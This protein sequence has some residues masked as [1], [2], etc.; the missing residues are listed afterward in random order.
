MSMK[1]RSPI[2][3]S[4]EYSFYNSF[5]GLPPSWAT[6][7]AQAGF[8]DDEIAEIHARRAAGRSQYLFNDRP[9]S[10]AYTA[11]E[12]P[13]YAHSYPSS[14]S[15]QTSDAS[16]VGPPET[17]QRSPQSLFPPRLDSIHSF[18]SPPQPMPPRKDSIDSQTSSHQNNLSISSRMRSGSVDT[19]MSNPKGTSTAPLATSPLSHSI[20][21]STPTRRTFHVT[22]DVTNSPP[23]SYTNDSTPNRKETAYPSEKKDASFSDPP[24]TH[25]ASNSVSSTSSF[26]VPDST[27][28]QTGPVRI[29]PA[30]TPSSYSSASGSTGSLVL[31]SRAE[32]PSKRLT[33]LP[34]RLSLHKSTDST[35]LSSW[36]ATLLSGITAGSGAT[37]VSSNLAPAQNAPLASVCAGSGQSS[38]TSLSVPNPGPPVAITAKSSSAAS[39]PPANGRAPPPSRPVP[40]PPLQD[41]GLQSAFYSDDDD[42]ETPSSAWAEPAS[43]ARYD[44]LLDNWD[45]AERPSPES[46]ETTS[47]T[48]HSLH[49]PTRVGRI[50]GE[51]SPAR[52]DKSR[53]PSQQESDDEDESDD[54]LLR[55]RR[56]MGA[57]GANRDSS[58]S[59]T[60]TVL[61]EP[62]AIVR[63]VSIARRVEAY[64]IDNSKV[65]GRRRTN[66]GGDETGSPQTSP[67]LG[68]SVVDRKQPPSPLSSNFGSEEGSASTSGSSST[69]SHGHQ[70]PGSEA[71]IASP[72]TYYLDSSP[73]PDPSKLTFPL[74]PHSQLKMSVIDTFGIVKEAIIVRPPEED[75]IVPSPPLKPTI[76]ITNLTSPGPP[77]SLTVTSGGTTPRTPFQRYPGWLSSVVEP[78]EQFIDE[79]VD[80][81]DYYLDLHEIAEGDSGSVFA[82]RLTKTNRHKLKLP[83]LIKARDADDL[84]NDRTTLVAIKSVAILPSGSPKLD[85]LERELSLMKGL[86][87]EHVLSMDA[88]Y[89]DLVEDTLWIRM[90]LMER[91]LADIIGLV[92]EGLML[93]D[94]M[95]ARFASDVRWPT[96]AFNP[97]F[98]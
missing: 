37:F 82:S 4:T 7:L 57:W 77:S 14:L 29:T 76:I 79:A 5:T 58:R 42:A 55:A 30:G 98:P 26:R 10:P 96:R 87:H 50:Q 75:D 16:R 86:G 24:R 3:S 61:A 36:G 70:T 90:E 28:Q 67:P 15:R 12:S 39:K 20:Q 34:P 17:G 85:D 72:L 74:I 49:G 41:R 78:L 73:S 54:G 63:K 40:V 11:T 21:P 6:S 71:D 84:A 56:E 81:R 2:A 8:S 33:A 31:G 52:L 25:T 66:A 51:T 22:N 69:L 88:V 97:I 59:S 68:S 43:T 64:V 23:P 83:P 62:A 91:S 35:D 44:P 92:P 48:W 60:S 1:C 9:A 45:V 94:R 27:P 89:V 18:S 13:T 46:P 80:P 53:T 32:S 38:S 93:H 95:I 19:H 47:T 65:K